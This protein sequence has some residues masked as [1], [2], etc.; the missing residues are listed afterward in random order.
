MN[1]LFEW[2]PAKA[3]ANFAKHGVTFGEAETVFADPL[4]DT[5][6]DGVHSLEEDRYVAIGRSARG[7]LLVVVYTYRED[8]IRIISARRAT[9]REA[10]AYEG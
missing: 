8:R 9:R 4:L 5:S 10:N 7:R 1:G 6:W 2:D 3:E